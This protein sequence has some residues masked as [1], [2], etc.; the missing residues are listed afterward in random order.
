MGYPFSGKVGT[1]RWTG[2]SRSSFPCSYNR[3]TAAAVSGFETLPM[4][5]CV[6][7]V[8]GRRRAAS[9]YPNPSDHTSVPSIAT[10]TCTPGMRG[11]SRSHTSERIRATVAR[12]S[13][14]TLRLPPETHGAAW[15]GPAPTSTAAITTLVIAFIITDPYNE[16]RK[17]VLRQ[18][19]PRVACLARAP[20]QDG[21]RD[22]AH[23]LQEA[24]R[25]AARVLQRRGRRGAVLRLDRQHLETDRRRLLRAALLAAPAHQPALRDESRAG[26]AS[27]RR[28]SHD[29]GGAGADPA[30][31]RSQE[32]R[33]EGRLAPPAGHPPAPARRPRRMEALPALPRILPA[34][35]HRLDRGGPA[36][37]GGIRAAAAALHQDDRPQQAL[38]DGPVMLQDL[39]GEADTI[40]TML[41][42]GNARPARCSSRATPRLCS[43]GR[44]GCA[45]SGALA[46]HCCAR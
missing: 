26:T 27:H 2:A 25:Q 15:E 42:S 41:R 18:E 6:A 5:N 7:R 28:P 34:N 44:C 21:S 20:P 32:R 33:Q 3:A 37:P 46:A 24:Q 13:A 16:S 12:Y 14:G 22:L 31:L 39:G 4:R 30:R 23:L 45:A 17:D 1:Y 36:S 11:A 40:A 19:S 38:R 9:A 10:A 8:T 35:S 29:Q 43:I